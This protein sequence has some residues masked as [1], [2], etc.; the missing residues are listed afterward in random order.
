MAFTHL[1]SAFLAFSE[2]TFHEARYVSYSTESNRLSLGMSCQ[3]FLQAKKIMEG[4]LLLFW[5][6]HRYQTHDH[7]E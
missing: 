2:D 3:L 7:R 4:L 1:A 5:L 6:M